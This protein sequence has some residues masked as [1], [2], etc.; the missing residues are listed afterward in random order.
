MGHPEYFEIL[1]QPIDF[2]ILGCPEYFE[3]LGQ[4]VDLIPPLKFHN[5]NNLGHLVDLIILVILG[6]PVHFKFSIIWDT[7]QSLNFLD[8]LYTSKFRDTL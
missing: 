8:T 2:I 3:I 7:L 6:H 1:G 5:F 4:P